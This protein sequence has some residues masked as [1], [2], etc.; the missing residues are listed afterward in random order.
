MV[1]RKSGMKP[2]LVNLPT[3]CIK[4]LDNLVK[5]QFYPS[6]NEAIRTAVRDLLISEGV[7]ENWQT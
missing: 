3:G 6:R 1:R 4:E 5:R 7:W 2:V